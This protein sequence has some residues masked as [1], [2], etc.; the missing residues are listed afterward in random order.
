MVESARNK[1]RALRTDI[2]FLPGSESIVELGTLWFEVS[3]GEFSCIKPE[4]E[5]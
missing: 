4:P 1:T 5:K 2:N 3:T